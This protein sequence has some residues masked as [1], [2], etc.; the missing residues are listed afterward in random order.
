MLYLITGDDQW[1]INRWIKSLAH[2]S[3]ITVI[4]SADTLQQAINT[5]RTTGLIDLIR[6]IWFQ[7]DRLAVTGKEA[8]QLIQQFQSI[9]AL[10]NILIIQLDAPLDQRTA[11]GKWL[12]QQ[13][14]VKTFNLIPNWQERELISLA[15]QLSQ[16]LGVNLRT[17]YLKQILRRVGNDPADIYGAIQKLQLYSYSHPINEDSIAA[18][19]P[20]THIQTFE[21]PKCLI[22]QQ[23]EA[24]LKLI[25][26]LPQ[27]HSMKVIYGV[28]SALNTWI[29]VKSCWEGGIIDRTT[30]AKQAG[31]ANPKQLYFIEKEL[32]GI[33]LGWLQQ[34]QS[35]VLSSELAMKSATYTDPLV[36]L[37]LRI[38]TEIKPIRTVKKNERFY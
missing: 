17:N 9:K 24:A 8:S 32:Q 5:V 30:V 34:V 33:S 25:R 4:Q 13:A 14:I 6:L 7:I 20:Q 35:E 23:T 16:E 27:Q 37:V 26:H 28:Y 11:L 21:L 19:V 3:N 38:C 1:S 2:Q 15:T 18:L 36:E 31:I 12:M 10:D 29:T 22:H